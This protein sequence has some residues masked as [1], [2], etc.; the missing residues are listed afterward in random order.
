[1]IESQNITTPSINVAKFATVYEH[2]N[3]Q[4]P[5]EKAI[6]IAEH[7]TKVGKMLADQGQQDALKGKTARHSAFFSSLVAL[8]FP[9]AL[10]DCK[11]VQTVADLWQS[12][13][14]DGYIRKEN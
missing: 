9:V 8:I 7:I 14:M 10:E 3:G 12:D 5:S 13:Y 1:M 4:M 11:T 2:E 6:Q